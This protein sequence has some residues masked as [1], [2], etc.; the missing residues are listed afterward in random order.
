MCG[1]CYHLSQKEVFPKDAY[2]E[3][4]NSCEECIAE[5]TGKFE[6]DDE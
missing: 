2:Q 1:N 4:R 3:I 6:D 5:Y